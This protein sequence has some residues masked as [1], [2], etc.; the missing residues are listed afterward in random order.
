MLDPHGPRRKGLVIETLVTTK[1]L[2]QIV[3]ARGESDLIDDLLVGFKYVADVLKRLGRDGRYRQVRR[4]PEELVLAAEESHGVI[5]L[6]HILDKDATP[7]CMYLAGLY[8]RLAAEGRTLL[9][10]Y[11]GILEAAGRLRHRQPVD[12]DGRGQR[13]AAQGPDHGLAARDTARAAWRATRCTA[14]I[15]YWDEKAV[16]PAGQRERAPAPQR[17]RSCRPTASSSPCGRRAP[18]PS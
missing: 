4:R 14:V 16:R 10:Y 5:A 15:D 11:I 3:A 6:P 13:H 2:G 12:H 8:Q 1:L 9:D 7:A 17:G 18:S